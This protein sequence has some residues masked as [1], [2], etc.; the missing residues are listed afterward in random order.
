M[1]STDGECGSGED[2]TLNYTF[3]HEITAIE[4]VKSCLKKLVLDEFSGC[5]NELWFLKLVF[6]RAR[7]L[8]KAVVVL[9]D[10]GN[11]AMVNEA[12]SRL[13]L[14][15]ST[16]WASKYSK[17]ECPLVVLAHAEPGEHDW[18]YHRASDLSLSDPFLGKA[19]Q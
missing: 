5:T 18:S 16:K 14:L 15:D 13:A 4:C 2:N 11:S 3:W 8:Q 17:E 9:P 6:A 12:M 1:Q 19:M 10:A 7:E